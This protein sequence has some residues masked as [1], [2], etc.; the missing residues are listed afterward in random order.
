M[1]DDDSDSGASTSSKQE[2]KVE[3]SKLAT[4]TTST[5][6]EIEGEPEGEPEGARCEIKNL[7]LRYKKGEIQTIEKNSKF[8]NEDPYM[9]Y[10]L[11]SKQSFD[12]QHKHTGTSLEINSPQLLSMLKDVVQYYPGE[13]LDFSTKFTVEDPY[14]IL[15]HHRKE[16]Q[17]YREESD[18]A[19]TKMH[20]ALLLEYLDAEAGSRGVAI[21]DMIKAGSITFPL[22][23]MIFKPGDLVYQYLNGHARLFQVRRHGYG[24]TASRG[25]YFDISGS[26]VSYD[27]FK[28]GVASERLR[29]WDRQEFFGLFS[30]NITGLTVFP[31]NF[32]PEEE[33][34]RLETKLTER[35]QRYLE[36]KDM[37]VKQYHGLFL[38][39]KRP[40]WD[41]YNEQADYDGAF[42][43]ETMSGRVVIDPRTFNEEAR[44]RKESI[45]AEES[46]GEE[47]SSDKDKKSSSISKE[48]TGKGDH[49]E[50]T[51]LDPRLCPSYV[52]GY[53]LE[54]KEWCKFF[55]DSLSD[56]NWKEN[57]MESLILPD[58]QKRLLKGLISGHEYPERARD[59]TKLKGKGLVILLHGSPG[60]GKTLTA[61]M[62]AEHTHRPLLNISTGELGSYQH[63]IE[64]ELKRLLTYASTFQ[65][66][67]LIDEADVFLEA[68]KSGPSD[69]LEQNAM[70]AVFLRQLEYFQGIIFLTS[71][72]VSV[73]DQAIKSR[74]H[75]ALQ[76]TSPGKEVRRMLWEKHLAHVPAEDIDLDLEEALATVEDT[77]MNGREISNA[78]TT[79]KTLAK[80]EGSKLKLEYLQTIIQVWF[81]F[82]TSL[83][84]LQKGDAIKI[85]DA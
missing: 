43:P 44:A 72:R 42:L 22:L 78:I 79:A 10:A 58:P 85:T 36:I 17:E 67:V 19:T 60:S 20:I 26:F 33:R 21:S 4:V 73:F 13:A 9:K 14:M 53:S 37:C 5:S 6:P 25:K 69:Q 24:E 70:V 71:N 49:L 31:L 46:D 84:K 11:V 76:Y 2:M 35:G 8:S 77:E 27:G 52:Y 59:E 18:D 62:T 74:I 54:K 16:I 57:A 56:V 30:A 65:A 68:R 12:E 55:V 66:I 29:I 83:L 47:E 48:M 38:Y 32:L 28:A 75:L 34:I 7:Q 3:D 81:E 82:E 45:A 63:R 41:Y 15:V 61:E 23:W 80:S 64:I 51:S 50:S 40:P 39:L 1:N